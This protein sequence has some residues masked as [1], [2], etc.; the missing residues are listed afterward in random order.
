MVW[1]WPAVI[2]VA[3]VAVTL[4]DPWALLQPGFWLS[5]GVVALLLAEGA[6]VAMRQFNA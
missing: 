3:V 6:D 4:L 5:F 1:R 2:G